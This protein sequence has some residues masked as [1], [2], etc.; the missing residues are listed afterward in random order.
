[1]NS[2]KK[3]RI[4]EAAEHLFRTRQ[5]HEITLEEVAARAKV[6]KGT[7]YLYFTDKP[8]LFFQTAV[9]GFD[10][11]CDLLRT[12]APGPLAFRDD[13]LRTCQTIGDFFYERRP[14][15]RVLPPDQPGG[16]PAYVRRQLVSQSCYLGSDELQGEQVEAAQREQGDHARAGSR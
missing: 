8:D 3:Q 1:M 12:A 11:M 14:L 10:R 6:G 15:F 9:A 2:D 16:L 4:M 7:I 5:F 13:L